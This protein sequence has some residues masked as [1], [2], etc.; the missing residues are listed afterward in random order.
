MKKKYNKLTM[1]EFL[2]KIEGFFSS[3]IE[4]KEKD[5]KGYTDSYETESITWDNISIN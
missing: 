5:F 4:T 1:K 3:S 2:L